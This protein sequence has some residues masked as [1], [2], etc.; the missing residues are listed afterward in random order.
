MN[1]FEPLVFLEKVTALLN[2]IP[3]L[4]LIILFFCIIYA[5]KKFSIFSYLFL[6][7][8]FFLKLD[9]NQTFWGTYA[10]IASLLA[11]PPMRRN[12]ITRGLIQVIKKLGLLP[13]ISETEKIALTS[14]PIWV[15]GE[16]FHSNVWFCRYPV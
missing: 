1:N 16:L 14:G 11:I 3:H 13:K 5:Y 9:L 7:T 10:V 6:L 8:I 12:F 4:G 15:D 2:E